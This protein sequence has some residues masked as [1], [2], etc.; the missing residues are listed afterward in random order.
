MGGVENSGRKFVNRGNLGGASEKMKEKEKKKKKKSVLGAVGVVCRNV[1][2][3]TLGANRNL[4][5]DGG[6]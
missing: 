4:R 6:V 3:L 5:G 1:R 2:G